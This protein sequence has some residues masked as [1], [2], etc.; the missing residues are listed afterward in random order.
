MSKALDRRVPKTPLIFSIVGGAAGVG[1]SRL[2]D[3]IRDGQ[4]LSTGTFFSTH[5]SLSD[6]DEVRNKD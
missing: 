6:R 4:K 2:L 1:K 3:E 5:M